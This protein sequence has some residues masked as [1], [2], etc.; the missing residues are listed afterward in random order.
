M[1][2][3]FTSSRLLHIEFARLT[4]IIRNCWL[5]VDPILRV[6]RLPIAI[7]TS[8]AKANYRITDRYSIARDKFEMD[9]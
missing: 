7:V 1:D 4:F 6:I 8:L 3:K 5:A 2:P 9:I